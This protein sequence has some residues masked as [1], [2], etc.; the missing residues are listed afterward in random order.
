MNIPYPYAVGE[1]TAVSYEL[2]TLWSVTVKLL[3]SRFNENIFTARPL[4]SSIKQLPV[5]GEVVLLLNSTDSY[6]NA[7]TPNNDLYYIPIPLNT[8]NDLNHNGLPG[9][10]NF[11]VTKVGSGNSQTYETG[12]SKPT[13]SKLDSDLHGRANGILQPFAGDTI[14]ESRYGSAIRFSTTYKNNYPKSANWVKAG[15][16]FGDPITIIS[17][18]KRAERQLFVENFSEDDSTITMTSTQGINLNAASTEVDSID[19]NSLNTWNSGNKFAGR[20]IIASSGR[21]VLNSYESET[22]LF[23]KKGVGI[24]TPGSFAI[25]AAK[26]VEFNTSKFKIGLNADEPIILGNEFKQWASDLIDAIGE[27]TVATNVGPTGPINASP[28]WPKI[29]ALKNKFDNNLSKLA[30]VKR[31][32]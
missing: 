20:Q 11:Q 3:N 21:I 30:F 13:K 27:I 12:R 5:I 32:K 8:Q 14:I 4:H 24:S 22:I 10:S 18:S 2:D 29:I 17:T 26:A 1:V 25:D 16:T 19:N 31:T 23:S 28:A 7:I 6:A 9:V 15:G